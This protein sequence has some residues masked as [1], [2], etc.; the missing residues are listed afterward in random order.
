MA[1]SGEVPVGAVMHESKQMHAAGQPKTIKMQE[2]SVRLGSS[3]VVNFENGQI[4]R[5][6][7]GI[8]GAGDWLELVCMA[9][10]L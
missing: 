8:D 6:E 7:L 2:E 5:G 3:S 4:G 10:E 1:V 9:N